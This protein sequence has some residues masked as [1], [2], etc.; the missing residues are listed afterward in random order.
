MASEVASNSNHARLIQAQSIGMPH[1]WICLLC[2][3]LEVLNEIRQFALGL[4][5]LRK[6]ICR[7][8]QSLLPSNVLEVING[9]QY[10][11]SFFF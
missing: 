10:Q 6:R 7:S 11:V 5:G 2:C 8:F 1:G 3:V 9:G 4:G